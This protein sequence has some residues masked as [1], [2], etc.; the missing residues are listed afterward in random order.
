MLRASASLRAWRG[1]F[2]GKSSVESHKRPSPSRK[3]RPGD[4]SAAVDRPRAAQRLAA[5][6]QRLGHRLRDR[7]RRT[8]QRLARFRRRPE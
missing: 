5:A 2:S 7:F 3:A 6:A 1:I 8:S 4:P